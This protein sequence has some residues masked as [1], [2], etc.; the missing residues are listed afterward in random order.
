MNIFKWLKHEPVRKFRPFLHLERLET[1][2]KPQII[3]G[4]QLTWEEKRDGSCLT[5]WLDDD[6]RTVHI[7]SRNQ[8]QAAKEFVSSCQSLQ[9]YTNICELLKTE[10][11]RYIVYGEL[12]AKG[13]GPTRIEGVHDKPEL[14]VFDMFD[15]VADNYLSYIQLYQVC[16]HWQI[17]VVERWAVTQHA[18]LDS[19]WDMREKI[20]QI[21]RENKREG[22][23]IKWV[24][25]SPKDDPKY[26]MFKEKLD[27]PP[28]PKIKNFVTGHPV[29]PLLPDSEVRGELNKL[30]ADYGLD[31]MRD[32]VKCM[33][34]FAKRV[35]KAAE[36]NLC[37]PPGT[38][39]RYYL[40]FLREHN[41]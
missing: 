29:L 24:S 8:A 6:N 37:R 31:W 5:F 35:N 17:P 18:T 25:S 12:I 21:A 30:Y 36:E 23:V 15:T 13:M 2:D 4:K 40:D 27:I 14:V 28:P 26:I 41:A 11:D 16:Y 9:E 3:L 7:S 32:K 38:I 1:M 22:T 10:K 39:Y 34:E 19:F 33:P 20:L